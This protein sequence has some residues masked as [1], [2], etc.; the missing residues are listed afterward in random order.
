MPHTDT[1]IPHICI[2]V[3]GPA[4]DLNC[5]NSEF[6]K[7]QI[8]GFWILDI[9]YYKFMNLLHQC[10]ILEDFLEFLGLPG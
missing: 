5:L 7:V 2:K 8:L 1:Y 6:F 10:N 3:N 9:I 4:I